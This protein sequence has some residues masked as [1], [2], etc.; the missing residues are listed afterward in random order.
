MI[1]D[2]LNWAIFGV[3]FTLW[4]WAFMWAIGGGHFMM[5]S[6]D[7]MTLQ[8]IMVIVTVIVMTL[9]NGKTSGDNGINHIISGLTGCVSMLVGLVVAFIV[10]N[11]VSMVVWGGTFDLMALANASLEIVAVTVGSVVMFSALNAV[12]D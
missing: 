6:V 2:L 8:C 11:L 10:V 1:K 4:A 5:A 3:A 7:G 12:R 9:M